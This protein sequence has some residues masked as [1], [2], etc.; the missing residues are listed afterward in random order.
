MMA[1][2]ALG[3][4]SADLERVRVLGDPAGLPAIGRA[5][6]MELLGGLNQWRQ[7]NR[8]PETD[9]MIDLGTAGLRDYE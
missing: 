8:G 4:R 6:A 9:S 5:A 3:G 2:T 1:L 7:G